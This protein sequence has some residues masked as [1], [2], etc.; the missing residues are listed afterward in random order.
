MLIGAVH[1]LRFMIG[2][3]TIPTPIGPMFALF[4]LFAVTFTAIFFALG[5]ANVRRTAAHKRF[6]IAADLPALSPALARLFQTLEAPVPSSRCIRAWWSC[7]S[8][9]SPSS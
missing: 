8:C 7:T 4:D 3:T 6:I 9:S 1:I 2:H 5:L